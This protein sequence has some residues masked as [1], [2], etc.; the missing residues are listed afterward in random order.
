MMISIIEFLNDMFKYIIIIGVIILIR[1]FALTST[2]VVGDSMEPTLKNG[3][4]VLVETVT[5]K[6]GKNER[7]DVVVVKYTSPKYIIKRIIGLPNETIKYVN[8]ELY[9]DNIKIEEDFNKLGTIEDFE[10]E[11]KDNEY[12]IIGDNRD[13]SKDSRS[14]GPINDNEV[15]GKPIIKLWPLKKPLF[16]K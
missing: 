11:L 2:E 1:I 9:I 8:N 5:N 4:M 14:F 12:F 6:L 15:I 7:F 13:D 16:V 3:N 10:L